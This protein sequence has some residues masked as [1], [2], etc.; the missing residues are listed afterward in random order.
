[1]KNYSL[2]VIT[3][4]TL[5]RISPADQVLDTIEPPVQACHVRWLFLDGSKNEKNAAGADELVFTKM[6][7]CSATVIGKSDVLISASCIPDVDATGPYTAQ[8]ICDGGKVVRTLK[9]L[10]KAFHK[11]D[12]T[13]LALNDIAVL[14][15]TVEMDIEPAQIPKDQKKWDELFKLNDCVLFGYGD[16]VLEL[17]AKPRAI[18]A[19]IVP[20]ELA[21]KMNGVGEIPGDKSKTIILTEEQVLAGDTGGGLMCRDEK[22]QWFAMSVTSYIGEQKVDLG[23]TKPMV[24]SDGRDFKTNTPSLGV[25]TGTP[26]AAKW[27]AEQT[28]EKVLIES[29][30]RIPLPGQDPVSRPNIRP[31]GGSHK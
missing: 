8:V 3:L 2:L 15:T 30:G 16:K 25:L 22:K 12:R 23:K 13:K 11:Y 1:M 31:T 28:K 19:Y 18:R 21:R 24:W 17:D 9:I 27:I 20:L 4:L 26:V 14:K 6:N 10:P 29:G 5:T 7:G